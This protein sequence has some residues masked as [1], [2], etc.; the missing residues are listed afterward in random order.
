[1]V[2]MSTTLTI[3]TDR[4]LRLAL[5][6]RAN[7]QG[8]TVS[9]VAREILWSGLEER[10]LGERTSHLRGRLRL[11]QASGEHWKRVLRQGNWRS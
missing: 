11:G 10:T 9:E 7:S 3:R 4:A 5:E 8:K 2:Y 6:K 1:M